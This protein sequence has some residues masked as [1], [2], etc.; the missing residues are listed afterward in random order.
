MNT[1]RIFLL[2]LCFFFV[3]HQLNASNL[4][5]DPAILSLKGSIQKLESVQTSFVQ[6][7]QNPMFLSTLS[8]QGR[9]VF[10]RPDQLLWEYTTPFVE[11]FAI[12]GATASKWKD[13][14][15]K[16][17][18]FATDTDPITTVLAG[19]LIHWITLDLKWIKKSYSIELSGTS[20]TTLKLTPK[21]DSL[22]SI[23]NHLLITF[24]SQGVAETVV[25]HE[26]SGQGVTTIRFF[27]P[28]INAPLASSTFTR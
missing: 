28:L 13:S 1:I 6:E 16:A 20:P 9:F 18:T 26:Q 4:E 17:V 15:D 27:D 10:Q 8:S 25:I 19:E 11:G 12:N 3:P 14:R 23:I 7:T 21:A 22:S 5:N 24:N 2:S